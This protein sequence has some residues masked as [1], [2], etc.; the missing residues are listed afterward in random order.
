MIRRKNL[1]DYPFCSKTHVFPFSCQ[2]KTYN[3]IDEYLTTKTDN[4]LATI[5]AVTCK[6]FNKELKEQLLKIDDDVLLVD[7]TDPNNV[8]G[9]T[10]TSLRVVFKYGSCNAKP[11]LAKELRLKKDESSNQTPK[12]VNVKVAYIR[13]KYKDVHEWMRDPNNVYIGRTMF[14][15]GIRFP[16]SIWAN[17]HKITEKVSR[18]EVLKLYEKDI[19]ANK[20]LMSK[21]S[22]LNGKNLGCWCKPE[23][24]HGDV[25]VKLYNEVSKSPLLSENAPS[26]PLVNPQTITAYTDGSCNPNPG[27]G[28]WGYIIIENNKEIESAYGGEDDTTN[29]LMEMTAVIKALEKFPNANMKIYTDSQ[30]VINGA[31]GAWKLNKNLDLW[32]R[33]KE[34]SKNRKIEYVWVRGHDGNKFNEKVDQLAKRGGFERKSLVNVFPR[35]DTE[36]LIGDFELS[37]N[38]RKAIWNLELVHNPPVYVYGKICN[39]RRDV[40]FFSDDATEYKY[41]GRSMK[42]VP[43]TPELKAIMKRVNKMTNDDYNGILVNKYSD[44]EDTIGK[45]RDNERELGNGGKVVAIS[46]GDSRTF[47]IRDLEGNIVLNHKTK[48]GEMMIMGTDFQKLYTHEIPKEAN[49]KARISLTFRKHTNLK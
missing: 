30:Y 35:D 31:T 22:T 27:R 1:K 42:A 28:G 26:L 11:E 2:G 3:T 19:R 15:N 24:C 18:D 4:V 34:L 45:H 8:L 16:S 23:P 13:P 37:D 40:Q 7:T 20:E 48:D 9:K 6:F 38:E 5:T 32:D 46:L 29:N 12:V 49:K 39:Q 41:S 47:R 44:G 14:V 17:K 33:L 36:L 25:L 43:L 21:I 10:L